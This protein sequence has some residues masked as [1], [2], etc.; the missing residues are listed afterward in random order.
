MQVPMRMTVDAISFSAH[1][2]FPQTAEFIDALAPAHVVLVHGEGGEMGRLRKALE[3]RAAVA[4]ATRT[5][6]TPKLAQPVRIHHQALHIAKVGSSCHKSSLC[7]AHVSKDCWLVLP[8][9]QCRGGE[10]CYVKDAPQQLPVALALAIASC[11]HC[12]LLAVV[13]M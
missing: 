3:Q 2:D 8:T 12:P 5:L 13:L 11:F 7:P 4:G 6:H 1:A 10:S 9:C